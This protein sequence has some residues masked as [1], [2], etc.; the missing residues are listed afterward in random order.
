MKAKQPNSGRAGGLSL[1]LALPAMLA[2]VAAGP[3]RAAEPDELADVKQFNVEAELDK[4]ERE[5]N[6]L[7]DKLLLVENEYGGKAEKKRKDI[8]HEATERR[9]ND[10]QVFFLTKDYVRAAIIFY[11]LVE[12]PDY[13]KRPGHDERV[14]MLAESMFHNRN[15][16]GARKYYSQVADLGPS[17]PNFF[18]ALPRLVEIA[19]ELDQYEGLDRHFKRLRGRPRSEVGEE[20]YYIHAKS[21]FDRGKIDEAEEEFAAFPE[22]SAFARRALYFRGVI[23]VNRGPDQYQQALEKFRALAGLPEGAESDK[24]MLDLAQL[25]VGRVLLEQNKLDDAMDSYQQISRYSPHFDDSLYETTWAWVRRGNMAE[26]AKERQKSFNKALDTLELLLAALPD[27]QILPRAKLLKGDLLLRMQKLDSAT[28]AYEDV[29]QEFEPVKTDLEQ[30]FAEHEDPKR[31]FNEIMGRN[32]ESFDAAAFLPPKAVK[33]AQT[34]NEV[35]RALHA[36]RDLSDGAEMLKEAER[37]ATQLGAAA[38]TSSEEGVLPRLRDGRD[39]A[40]AVQDSGNELRRVLAELETEVLL[41]AKI[42]SGVTPE[43]RAN[44]QK[45]LDVHRTIPRLDK[46]L[47]S[48][49]VL[50]RAAAKWC[51]DTDMER[52]LSQEENDFCQ[53]RVYAEVGKL[54]ELSLEAD[55]TRQRL[56]DTMAQK[57]LVDWVM[58]EE[59]RADRRKWEKLVNDMPKTLSGIQE[60]DDSVAE[61]LAGLQQELLRLALEVENFEAQ[62]QAIESWRRESFQRRKISKEHEDGFR[63]RVANE[64]AVVMS[65][66]ESLSGL[67]DEVAT[68]AAKVS[69]VGASSV[70]DEKTIRA[71]Y[72]QA[73]AREEE[74]FFRLRGS[75]GGQGKQRVARIDELRARLDGLDGTIESFLNG[76]QQRTGEQTSEMSGDLAQALGELKAYAEEITA[77]RDEAE[78]VAGTIAYDSFQDVRE[79]FYRL[80]LRADVG[81]IDV[82]WAESEGQNREKAD[83]VQKKSD[84][85]RKVYNEFQDVLD[86]ME[87]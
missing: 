10:A 27:S 2:L 8:S 24:E 28:E 17:N 29:V 37:I 7:R 55:S 47:E 44:D 62:L 4:V 18:K 58:Y 53:E 68:E 12:N 76:M 87:E 19:A 69:A 54:E 72:E 65:L 85:I 42:R 51:E 33:W 22:T 43:E 16:L 64:L 82:A 9:F 3:S 14:F 49:Y 35:Q 40:V 71:K 63:E 84:E 57:G 73:L 83:L 39:T 78:T 34:S 75:L 15:F 56:R 50:L 70:G 67:Q 59:A 21:L 6:K 5:I 74:L 41:E 60:R 52:G 66:R 13:N 1:L 81:L 32:I 26:D 23:A 61:G 25:A 45:V 30:I 46:E 36:V 20:I 79:Q 31:Y 48:L 11:D 80:V 38:E 77:L 86:D